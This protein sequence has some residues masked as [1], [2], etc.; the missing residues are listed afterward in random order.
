MNSTAGKTTE[1][2]ELSDYIIEA[3]EALK[4]VIMSLKYVTKK[5]EDQSLEEEENLNQKV[6]QNTQKCVWNFPLNWPASVESAILYFFPDTKR[7]KRMNFFT[8]SSS[9]RVLLFLK[10]EIDMQGIFIGEKVL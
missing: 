10:R 9:E 4:Q 8:F 1:G 5:L 3:Y 7:K 2:L 6:S